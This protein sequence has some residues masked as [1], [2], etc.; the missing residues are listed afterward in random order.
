[1][2]I[3]IV[4]NRIV[5][6]LKASNNQNILEELEGSLAG[7]ATGSEAL[8]SSASYLSKLKYN[9]PSVYELI[10][11]QIKDYIDYCKQNGLIIK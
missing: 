4:Y 10:R 2:D 6:K 8:M 9:H 3:N 5:E 1:M 11:E 7:A